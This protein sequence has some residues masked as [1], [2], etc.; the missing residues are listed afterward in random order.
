MDE[1]INTHNNEKI[2]GTKF[3]PNDITSANFLEFLNQRNDAQDATMH[4][5]TNC[6]DSRSIMNKNWIRSL[7]KFQPGQK[8]LASRYSLEGRKAFDKAS[9]EGT[10]ADTPYYIERAKLH[11]SRKKTLVPGMCGFLCFLSLNTK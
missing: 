8:V 5:N 4:F 7:F 10:Y 6:I 2:E 9:V 11:P 3:S 1:V